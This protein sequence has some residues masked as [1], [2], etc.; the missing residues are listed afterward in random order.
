LLSIAK[1]V[2]TTSSASA[3]T[4]ATTSYIWAVSG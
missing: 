4:I 2:V 3:T 1:Q